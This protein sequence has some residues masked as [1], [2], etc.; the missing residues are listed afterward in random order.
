MESCIVDA[1]RPTLHPFAFLF[2]DTKPEDARQFRPNLRGCSM[3][4]VTA[5]A[6]LGG[7][8]AFDQETIG[9]PGGACGLCL[10]ARFDQT[11]GGIGHFLSTGRGDGYPEG[12]HFLATPELA[13]K[14]VQ[15][16]PQIKTDR[17]YVVCKA[18]A[19]VEPE[20]DEPVSVTILG[21]ADQISALHFLANFHRF[22]GEGVVAT[23]GAACHTVCLQPVHQGTLPD[24]KAVIGMTDPTARPMLEPDHLAFSIPWKLFL[25]MEKNAPDSFLFRHIWGPIAKRLPR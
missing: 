12:E 7:S 17:T 20:E 21:N 13:E 1:L 25:T 4:L 9:C 24:P 2:S 8:A 18:L 23:W 10:G 3:A 19:E 22:D 16:L 5:V 11:P 15:S 6:K 14:W